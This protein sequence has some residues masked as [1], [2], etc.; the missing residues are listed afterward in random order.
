MVRTGLHGGRMLI[1]AKPE[2]DQGGD[3]FALS[4]AIAPASILGSATGSALFMQRV[5]LGETG[6]PNVD[7]QRSRVDAGS[8]AGAAGLADPGEDGT[9]ETARGEGALLGPAETPPPLRA[10]RKGDWRSSAPIVV[11][12][13]GMLGD[14]GWARGSSGRFLGA[15]AAGAARVGRMSIAPDRVG[16]MGAPI[17]SYL[18]YTRPIFAD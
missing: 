2:H 5:A 17:A 10:F 3:S 1:A 6:A 11:A 14:S 13:S 12:W 7:R 8:Q 4:G 18:T 16:A 15:T 9:G